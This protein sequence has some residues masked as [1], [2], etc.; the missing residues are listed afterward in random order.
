MPNTKHTALNSRQEKKGK[1]KIETNFQL[2][3]FTSL[4][5]GDM[6]I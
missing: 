3:N 6:K 1:K 5:K 2:E 4:K